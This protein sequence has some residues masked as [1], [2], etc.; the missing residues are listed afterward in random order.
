VWLSANI[1][2]V[3]DDMLIQTNVPSMKLTWKST[4]KPRPTST[5]RNLNK[6]SESSGWGCEKLKKHKNEGALKE[7]KHYDWKHCSKKNV[8]HKQED[9]FSLEKNASE[10]PKGWIITGAS[11]VIMELSNDEI[12]LGGIDFACVAINYSG[13]SLEEIHQDQEEAGMEFP[14]KGKEEIHWD[15]TTLP[16]LPEITAHL[17]QFEECEDSLF[18]HFRNLELVDSSQ[19]IKSS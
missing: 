18:V 9:C 1:L 6:E 17:R 14:I 2:A 12:P 13:E 19:D 11:A 8:V 7:V 10:R 4:V 15:S 5:P 3:R 16:N